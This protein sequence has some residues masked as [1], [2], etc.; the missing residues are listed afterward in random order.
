MYPTVRARTEFLFEHYQKK[1]RA[2]LSAA[3]WDESELKEL[4]P[5]LRRK[6]RETMQ[7]K[8]ELAARIET[9]RFNLHR[10]GGPH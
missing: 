8:D 9:I 7:T 5:I 4:G 3:P 6:I 2:L 10:L 1:Y